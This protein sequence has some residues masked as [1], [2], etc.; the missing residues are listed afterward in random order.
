MAPRL[1][2]LVAAAWTGWAAVQATDYCK[3]SPE[4]TMCKYP[5]IGPACGT[6][7]L[8]REV[9]SEEADFI[10]ELH[11]KLRS[12]V[13]RGEETRGA[14]GP[15]P[16][17]ANIRALAWDEELATVA[18]RHADQ[19]IFEHDCNDCRSVDRFNVGQNIY[20]LKSWGLLQ[21]KPDWNGAVI[22]F[23]DE[24]DKFP[25]SGV[26]SY[27][28]STDTGH[29]TQLL[30]GTTSLVGCGYTKFKVGNVIKALYVCNYGPIG[31]IMSFPMYR[32]GDPCS[33]CPEGTTCSQEYEGLCEGNVVVESTWSDLQ[34]SVTAGFFRNSNNNPQK[35]VTL[36]SEGFTMVYEYPRSLVTAPMSEP[37]SAPT[38]TTPPPA[39]EN[40]GAADADAE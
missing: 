16:S 7:V 8:A 29:Y 13:A 1:C 18:Q 35:T 4:H 31:N 27:Q 32:E 2:L 34:P 17:G 23:Y 14:P 36:H 38:P 26:G 22:S 19:C 9:S 6:Q 30:W 21:E 24:V 25:G 33:A 20:I 12:K 39:T 5:G 10:V 40:N 28:F 3:I 11:N 15:Q 37:T